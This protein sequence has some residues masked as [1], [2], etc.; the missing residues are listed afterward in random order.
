MASSYV[1]D[2]RLNE[3][4]TGDASGTWGTTTNTNLELIG[5]A[6]GYGTEAITTNADTHASTV[7]DGAADSARAMYIKYTG[8]LDSA[9]TITIGPNTMKRV[10][11]I[12]NATSGSQSIIIKQGSGA[13][14]TIPT[15]DTKVVML[16]GA[17][18]G[19]A[20]VDAFASLSVVDLKVQDDL[21]VT[22]DMTVGGT[23]GV[24]G[25]LTGTSLDISGDIDVD[26][27]TNLDVVDIDGAVDMASTLGVTGVVTANAGVVVDN[28]TLDG[29]TLALSS[30]DLTIDSAADIILDADG[31]DILFKDGGTHWLNFANS[32]GVNITSMVQDEDILFRGN[33]GGSIITALTLDMSAAGAATFN[34]TVTSTA[35]GSQLATTSFV[36]N[37][38]T[39]SVADNA[40]AFIRMAV[41]SA[42]NPTYSFEDDTNTGM[43]TSGADTLNFTTG[44]TQR[45]IINSSGAATF[46]SNVAANS[47]TLADDKELIF[48]SSSDFKIYHSGNVNSIKTNSDLPLHFL[49]AGGS[50]MMSFTPNTGLVIN[51]AGE[52]FNFRIESDGNTEMFSVD[53][54]TNQVRI[55]TGAGIQSI[56]HLGVRQNGAAIEFGHENNSG[57]FYGTLGA[58]GSSG[59][60]YIGFSTFCEASAN[61]F[62]TTGQKGSVIFGDGSG[63]LSFAQVSTASAT[64]QSPV[65][66]MTLTEAGALTLGSSTNASTLARFDHENSGGKAELQLNAHGSA[67]FSMLSNF[68]GSTVTGVATGNFGLV[69]PHNAAI[70]IS[71]S[72]LERFLIDSN[73]NIRIN[74]GGVD[75]DF[76]VETANQAHTLFIEGSTDLIGVRNDDPEYML[77][78]GNAAQ[79]TS[80]IFRG[81]VNGDFIFNL[82]KATTSLFSIRNNNVGVVTINTQNNARLAF[83][84]NSGS[85]AGSLTEAMSIDT[86]NNVSVNNALSK[87]SGSFK[88]KHPLKPETH[89]LIHSFVEGPQADNIYRGV[90]KLENGQAVIDIDERYNMTPGTFVALNRDT[91]VWVNNAE[92]WD[93]V[94]AN[95]EGSKITIECQN[96]E[97]N[98]TISWLAMGERQ[99][100]EIYASTLTDDNGRIIIEPLIEQN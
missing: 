96:T 13:T 82:R 32:S 85:S 28:F 69:T 79:T 40:G 29:T 81:T 80:N 20:V 11:I 64:G 67:S 5:N 71:T 47:I 25:V 88:I 15:G 8:T 42:G 35:F 83:G 68:T 45:L 52:D 97:S 90:T 1:N 31:A 21:T 49:D 61:T 62:T 76:R 56:S 10:H 6:L 46:A 54:G 24:T 57:G 33:D 98:A 2:L 58:F 99:D 63:N 12:E 17:G 89:N 74:E 36:Q 37:V 53:G 39:T 78:V 72:G 75:A 44:G 41:S 19:A 43:F 55:G 7:A 9:C 93:L 4:A 26:G 30:G 91:Q 18:S 51:E 70:S 95:I 65:T 87:G 27:T 34:S 86:N 92:T 60:P 16:D 3:M 59:R 23:L 66:Y 94:R 77:D 100:K 84:V 73:G 50:Q 38:L 14:I 48:G 22:D